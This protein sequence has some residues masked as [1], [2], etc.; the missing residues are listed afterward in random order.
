[1]NEHGLNYVERIVRDR[2]EILPS[3]RPETWNLSPGHISNVH[4][5]EKAKQPARQGMLK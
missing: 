2:S 5:A 4:T 1:M 3:A